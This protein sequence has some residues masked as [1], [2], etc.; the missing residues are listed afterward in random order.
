MNYYEVFETYESEVRSYCR[1]FP[2]VFTTA[3]GSRIFDIDGK[4]YID[5]LAGCGALNYGHNN[6]TIKAKLVEYIQ[7]DGILH[8]MDMYTKA[9]A[10]F[11]EYFEEEIIKKRGFDYKIQFTGPTGTNA[12]EASLKLA[13]KVKG[14]TSV[15]GLMG[16]FHGMT[17][18]ALSLTSNKTDRAGAGIPL[19]GITHIPAPYMFKELDTVKYMQ[20]LIDDDHSGIETPAAII[21]ETV[22]AEGGIWPMPFEWLK[23]VRSFCDRNDIL[24]IVDDIQVG[25]ARTGTFF[26]FEK[27]GII[28]DMVVMAKST[29]GLGMPI[30]VVLLKPELDIWLPGEH[31]GTFRGNQL[32]MVAARAGLELMLSEHIEDEVFRKEQLLIKALEEKI[33]PFISADSDIRGRGLIWGIDVLDG[34]YAKAVS[35]E[36]FRNG[37]IA[38]RA[39]RNS[40]TIK[41]MPPLTIEDSLLLE[42]IDIISSA[43]QAESLK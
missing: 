11:I 21:I 20:T 26:S 24:M 7:N 43:L 37:L 40:S 9:K 35:A 42:G 6:E 13:R 32:S 34:Q 25:T 3:K 23:E 18:G 8:S 39:G 16:C 33:R 15:W 5:F 2:A 30:A 17:L 14:R 29:G 31:N 36:C 4:G 28:P 12:V 27:A 19:G 10:E 41:I 1:N 22:Q 38:E